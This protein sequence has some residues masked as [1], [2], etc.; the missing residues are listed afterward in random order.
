MKDVRTWIILALLLTLG[1]GYLY[2]LREGDRLANEV[3]AL[4]LEKV[5]WNV[6][7]NDRALELD[8][9]RQQ[10]EDAKQVGSEP[11]VRVQVVTREVPVRV[12]GEA[13]PCPPSTHLPSIDTLSG[14]EVEE[15]PESSRGP[16]EGTW[17]PLNLPPLFVAARTQ[18]AIDL[19]GPGSQELAWTGATEVS[20]RRGSDLEVV[21]L[22]LD[23]S[24][25]S[26][27]L[28]NS[29]QDRLAGGR[30]GGGKTFALGLR[31]PRHWRTG[32]FAGLGLGCHLSPSTFSFIDPQYLDKGGSGYVTATASK[33]RPSV[34]AGYGVQ[35]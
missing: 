18:L 20:L 9:L 3:E 29:L 31:R 16:V 28:S 17:R 26:L 2:A 4:Q 27:A 13:I 12:P 35:F 1:G 11:E 24:N 32:W 10:L 23:E 8:L 33:C 7:E 15:V 21:S 25:T 30:R 19:L 5:G 34:M 22:P 14:V 6:I